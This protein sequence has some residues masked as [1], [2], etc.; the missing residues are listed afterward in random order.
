MS[1]ADVHVFQGYQGYL[2]QTREQLDRPAALAASEWCSACM[3]LCPNTDT[4]RCSHTNNARHAPHSRCLTTDP[5]P[6]SARSPRFS[7]RGQRA[8]TL[9]PTPLPAP[10]ESRRHDTADRQHH[11]IGSVHV[12]FTRT[13]RPNP[14]LAQHGPG[15]HNAAV[16]QHLLTASTITLVVC[17]CILRAPHGPIPCSRSMDPGVTTQLSTITGWHGLNNP[18]VPGDDAGVD[19]IYVDLRRNPEKYT[20]ACGRCACVCARVVC[21]RARMCLCNAWGPQQTGAAR[22]DS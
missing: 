12:Y 18:W 7:H 3:A 17:T 1:C 2:G 9:H 8:L 22:P 16:Y 13:S 11:H 21:A 20:G 19:Y 6:Q 10:L 15:R 5:R 4:A 14:L